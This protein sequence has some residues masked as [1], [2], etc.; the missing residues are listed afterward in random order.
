MSAIC[1]QV[2]TVSRDLV[3][4]KDTPDSP[5]L[6]DPAVPLGRPA[7]LELSDGPDPLESQA[8]EDSLDSKVLQAALVVSITRSP[9][10]HLFL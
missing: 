6:P 4:S 2:R 1:A 10:H 9:A 7:G 3:A 5:D 8:S